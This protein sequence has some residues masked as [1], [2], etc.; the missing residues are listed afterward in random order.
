VA[1]VTEREVRRRGL[2]YLE[3]VTTLA[4]R[5]RLQH[6]TAGIW[7]A[8]DL[9]WWWRRPRA[10]DEVAQRVV[11]DDEGQPLATVALIDWGEQWAAEPL[12][13]ADRAADLLPGI[14]SRALDDLDRLHP[15]A[16]E[17]SV[18]DD[19]PLMAE[20]A[21]A[22]GFSSA[23]G[24]AETWM[25]ARNR[26]PSGPPPEGYA[27]SDRHV[28]RDQPHHMVARNGPDVAARLA[29]TSLYRPDLDLC[30]RDHDG[31]LAA[32]ALFWYDPVTTVGMLEPM[33]TEDAYQRRGLG[34][35][36]L[37]EGLAR[38]AALG[39]TQLK[40]S[41]ELDNPASERLYL[42]SGFTA[43][44]TSATWRRGAEPG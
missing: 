16:V 6:P 33:R 2:A 13:L 24:Y 44:S 23:A 22:A 19:D 30:L 10:S 26:P 35:H 14:W 38:L 12:V 29:Q 25:E 40:V 32:Y 36:V 1:A 15:A 37:R 9:Q 3:A 21:A 17:T 42:S 28:G 7:E 8:A 34:G 20:L 39:A 5:A 31:R 11:I 18:A 41:Y 43:R 4:Q 27:L